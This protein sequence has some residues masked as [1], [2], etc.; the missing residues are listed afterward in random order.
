[1]PGEGM[2]GRGLGLLIL[3]GA[4]SFSGAAEAPL[5]SSGAGDIVMA[6]P[7]F[8]E[9][10]ALIGAVEWKSN[11]RAGRGGKVRFLRIMSVNYFTE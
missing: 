4:S 5:S 2:V 8:A 9:S 10:Q 1:M 11:D 6:T 3:L 7:I